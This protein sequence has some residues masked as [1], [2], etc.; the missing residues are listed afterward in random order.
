[1]GFYFLCFIMMLIKYNL[2]T[3]ENKTIKVG[4][5][6]PFEDDYWRTYARYF[7][8]SAEK[9]KDEGINFEIKVTFS[10]RSVSI[11]QADLE[12]LIANKIDVLIITAHD[13]KA[14]K[15]II[16]YCE[17]IDIPIIAFNRLISDVEL[18]AYISPN[19]TQAGQYQAEFLL[20]NLKKNKTNKTKFLVM[21]GPDSD[22]NSKLLFDGA[23]NIFRTDQKTKNNVDN[24]EIFK[25][26]IVPNW[27]PN[28]AERLCRELE[29]DFLKDLG[30]IVAA[31]DDIAKS[32]ISS[33]NNVNLSEIYIA[34]HDYSID[35]I[36]DLFE[37]L[38]YNYFTVDMNQSN[39]TYIAL[40]VSKNLVLGKPF[41]F[42]ETFKNG[43]YDN[44]YLCGNVRRVDYDTFINSRKNESF[45]NK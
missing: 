38:K 35:S 39:D 24:D 13:T 23:M 3:E 25:I 7:N 11:Q 34:G 14:S 32:C 36:V 40:N 42:R 33:L 17:L 44:P 4:L 27:D 21:R 1:M 22:I 18:K 41:E 5:S 43:Q 26:M 2:S 6:L 12:N 16:K 19:M 15:N 10:K 30:Y 20:E 31:N 28:E 37:M 9:F 8:K 45:D 29:D